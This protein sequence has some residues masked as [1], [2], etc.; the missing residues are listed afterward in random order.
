VRKRVVVTGLG[1]VTS[2]GCGI[3]PFWKVVRSGSSRVDQI[4]Q[5]DVSKYRT[6]IA[7]TFDPSLVSDVSLK[8]DRKLWD[9]TSLISLV[10]AQEAISS[11]KLSTLPEETGIFWGSA[12]GGVAS[13]D[14]QYR[15][16]YQKGPRWVMPYTLPR[17][18]LNASASLMAIELGLRG[19]NYVFGTACSSSSH[20][21]GTAFRMISQGAL[22]LCLTGGADCPISPGNL[23]AWDRLRALAND[24]ETPHRACRPFSRNRSGLVLGDGAATLVLEA[25]KHALERKANIFGEIV[26][27]GANCDALHMIQPSA[28]GQADCLRLALR[29]AAV[30]DQIPD[31]ISAHGTGTIEGDKSETDAIEQVFGTDSLRIPISSIKSVIGHTLGASGALALVA[32]LLA[33]RDGIIPPTANLEEPDPEC[34]LDY[35][36]NT[37]R[38][39]QIGFALVNSFAFGGSNAVLAVSRHKGTDCDRNT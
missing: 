8:S 21:I 33:I 12:A 35:V 32:T 7:A 14:D 27:Y 4:S 37:S 38:E 22:D 11:A 20:A 1:V 2:S 39:Q 28:E 24:N 6:R 10:S 26:G 18:M 19:P 13:I 9:L 25:R 29:D 3:K 36:P 30:A 16:F 17:I 34:D 23:Q 31:Y 5:F 15:N